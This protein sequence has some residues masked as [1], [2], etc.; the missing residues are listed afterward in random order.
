VFLCGIGLFVCLFCLWSFV[1]AGDLN[2]PAAPG[3]TMKT[4]DEVEP[5]TPIHQSDIPLT[6]T[7]SGSYYLAEDVSLAGAGKCI[8]VNADDVTIDLG[9]FVMAGSDSA[10]SYGVYMNGRSNVEIRNGTIRDFYTGIGEYDSANGKNHQVLGVRILSCVTDSVYFRYCENCRVRDC[11]IADGGTRT[12]IASAVYAICVGG[13]STV[14]ANSI[15]NYGISSSCRVFGVETG[16]GCTVSGNTIYGN[17]TSSTYDYAVGIWTGYNCTV[18]G[19][20]VYN[21]GDSTDSAAVFGIYVGYAGVVTGNSVYSNGGSAGGEVRGISVSD[22]STV[23]KN[24]V[25]DNGDSAGNIVYGIFN[26]SGCTVT[27]NTAYSNGTSSTGDNVCGIRVGTGSSVTGNT[28]HSN[29]NSASGDVYGIFLSG[30]DLANNNA[31]YNNVGTGGGTNL[32]A[33][34]GC[35]LGTNLAP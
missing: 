22:G 16:S 20:S 3:S 2:P 10:S 32:Y 29:G 14:T 4:L 6:I 11:T 25:Y 18:M 9:G 21:N 5:R 34:A 35:V 8:Q 7:V 33:L 1:K 26:G 17:G 28:A 27:E 30:S 23:T 19:N 12:G 13:G 24:T 15:Y 31:A